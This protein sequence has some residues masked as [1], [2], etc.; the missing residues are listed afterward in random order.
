VIAASSPLRTAVRDLVRDFSDRTASPGVLLDKYGRTL[1]G[2][3]MGILLPGIG[4]AIV[5]LF[6]REFFGAIVR[7]SLGGVFVLI[8]AAC[9]VGGVSGLREAGGA[10]PRDAADRKVGGALAT[11]VFLLLTLAFNIVLVTDVPR[12]TAWLVFLFCVGW[13]DIIAV[14]VLVRLAAGLV[15]WIRT[16]TGSD[17]G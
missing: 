5:G 12:A 17:G 13:F 9:L 14:A 11:A 4:I 7:Y 10:P 16:G 8:G 3:A 1:L 2:F 6:P 15:R